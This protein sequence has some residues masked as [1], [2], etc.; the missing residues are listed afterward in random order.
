[1]IQS[2]FE[3][4]LANLRQSTKLFVDETPVPV[5]D[6][7][8]GRTKTGYFWALGRDDRAWAGPE[9]PAVAFTYTPGRSG[10]YASE[11]LGPFEGILQVDG[12]TGYNRLRDT[13]HDGDIR[14]AYCWAHARRKLYELTVNNVAPIAEEGLKQITA[15]YRI[16]SRIRSLSADGRL[17]ARQ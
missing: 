15:L 7:R 1:V 16:E 2:A 14:R 6:P 13:R 4:L 8:R 10:K 5:L 12:Y 17:A 9:P 11:I 3:A